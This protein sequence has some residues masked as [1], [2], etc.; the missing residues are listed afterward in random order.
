MRVRSSIVSTVLV[1]LIG[2]VFATGVVGVTQ[3]Y[4]PNVST[5]NAAA[6][7]LSVPV[8]EW[9]AYWR[10]TIDNTSP[11]TAYDLL[12]TVYAEEVGGTQHE[13]AHR[14]GALLYETLGPAAIELCD[15]QFFYGCYH[16]VIGQTLINEGVGS[17][18]E[19]VAAC[20]PNLG[21]QHGVGHGVV[22]FHGYNEV[23]LARALPECDL[24]AN[25]DVI[26][27]CLG[28]VFM[29]YNMRTMLGS[30][31]DHELR[32]FDAAAPLAPCADIASEAARQSC[33]FWAPQWLLEV[34]YSKPYR[35][36]FAW[37]GQ[38]CRE[39]AGAYV[40]RC[41]EGIGYNVNRYSELDASIT[42]PQLCAY[43][44]KTDSEYADCIILAAADYAGGRFEEQAITWCNSLQTAH[45]ER[46]LS[47]VSYSR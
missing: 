8:A 38:L 42:T 24:V 35:E 13:Y 6:P 43:A 33:F 28:G 26:D 25:P 21:C 44:S 31:D 39:H 45:Q 34:D 11:Q 32:S 2:F 3:W 22:A 19:L 7:D 10:T 1:M 18:A 9:D 40:N 27:G 37:A 23:A 29:E 15:E 17:L 16:E 14:F 41:F 12:V 4:Q 36:R 5:V 30:D 47:T 46:C 20:G